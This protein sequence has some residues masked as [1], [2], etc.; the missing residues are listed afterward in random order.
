[1]LET[2]FYFLK[3]DVPSRPLAYVF[4]RIKGQIEQYKNIMKLR[5]LTKI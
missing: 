5:K 3:F 4:L 2:Y 1:M